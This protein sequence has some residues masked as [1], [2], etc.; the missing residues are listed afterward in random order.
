M[1]VT[2]EELQVPT[3]SCIMVTDIDTISELFVI[4][5]FPVNNLKHK[6]EHSHHHAIMIH[7]VS[8][9][10]TCVM[11]VAQVTASSFFP[12]FTL[13]PLLDELTRLSWFVF[14]LVVA[15]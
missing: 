2:C 6:V 9:V 15:S 13:L 1:E 12:L 11:Y 4:K 8:N 7:T 3:V 5:L 14:S 10:V